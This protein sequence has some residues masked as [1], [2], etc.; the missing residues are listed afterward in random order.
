MGHSPDIFRWRRYVTGLLL[1]K[2][3]EVRELEATL[4]DIE[5]EV[6]ARE[7]ALVDINLEIKALE[8]TDAS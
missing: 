8:S 5:A 4:A 7:K 3:R 1:T 2:R 6:E